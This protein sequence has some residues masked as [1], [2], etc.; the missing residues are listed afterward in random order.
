M[1][2][3]LPSPGLA[4]RDHFLSRLLFRP[5]IPIGPPGTVLLLGFVEPGVRVFRGFI[6]RPIAIFL[7]GR[8]IDDAG[9]MA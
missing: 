8:R 9:D 1:A 3:N 7:G 4:R 6:V 5:A 2:F